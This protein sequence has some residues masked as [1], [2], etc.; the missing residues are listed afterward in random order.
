[1]NEEE[2]KDFESKLVK[3]D[4][5]YDKLSLK[6][7]GFG[8]TRRSEIEELNNT[9]ATSIFE[10]CRYAMLPE[11][12]S[13]KFQQISNTE[14]INPGG[15]PKNEGFKFNY[16]VRFGYTLNFENSFTQ[17]NPSIFLKK[18]DGSNF[19]SFSE[20]LTL[21]DNEIFPTTPIKRTRDTIEYPDSF[22]IVL[23]F[24]KNKKKKNEID[25]DIVVGS[26]TFVKESNFVLIL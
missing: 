2:R 7:D 5:F 25:Q 1:M 26:V 13:P 16:Y 17:Q 15:L 22:H 19:T 12:H 4:K 21:F 14:S 8:K 24:R 11:F 6:T 3:L 23:F 20:V 18:E 10:Y 9:N